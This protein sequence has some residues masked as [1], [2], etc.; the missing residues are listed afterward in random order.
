MP[1]EPE[2]KHAIAFIDGQ[3]LFHHAKSAFGHEHPNYDPQKLHAEICRQNDWKPSL[4]R[5]YT[6]VHTFEHDELWSGYWSN[7]VLRMKRAG[8]VVTTRPLRYYP[9]FVTASDGTVTETTL[10]QEKGIDVRIALDIVR[11]ARTKQFDVGV[12]YSQDQDLAEVA[13]EVKEISQQQDRWIKLVSAFPHGNFATSARGVNGTD[14]VQI[15]QTTYD[16]CL[17]T[18]DYRPKKF[19]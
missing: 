18:Y 5:F 13:D 4:V 2:T 9:K 11:L 14:W 17:D 1:S 3:N 12:I 10:S 16:A 7:R 15:D 6:G 8:V 19:Q